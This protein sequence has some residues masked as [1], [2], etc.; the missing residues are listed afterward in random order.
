VEWDAACFTDVL[1]NPGAGVAGSLTWR[2]Q[3]RQW[4]ARFLAG[5]HGALV[6]DTEQWLDQG[7]AATPVEALA[8]YTYAFERWSDGSTLNP[9]TLA[10][11]TADQTLTAVFRAATPVPVSAGEFLAQVDLGGV[12]AG[13]GLWDLT[14]SY[15][16]TVLG[17]P[18]QFGLLHDSSG[19]L[20]GTAVYTP[21]QGDALNLPLKGSVKDA[22]AAVV[23][24]F[25]L[26][27]ADA[28]GVLSVSL[29]FNLA[30]DPVARTLR[31]HQ[32]GRI[33]TQGLATPVAQDLVLPVPAPMDGTWALRCDVAPSGVVVTGTAQ[34]A[35]A[36]GVHYHC[37]VQGSS[38]GSSTVLTLTGDAVDPAAR[39]L[40]FK[41][42][43]VTLEGGWALLQGCSGTGCGQTLAW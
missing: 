1:G 43:L 13:R 18:L 4:Q 16:T 15:A 37:T 23:A 19:K 9:R 22:G 38:A 21:A 34:L 29:T 30:L 8:D 32:T 27:G 36:N 31:G 7:Q 6:G 42:T 41:C 33:T 12:A 3:A 26:H 24:Q 14:G 2:F 35:L 11:V 39:G 10:P 17:N 20:T 5:A 28:A 40:R 25:V